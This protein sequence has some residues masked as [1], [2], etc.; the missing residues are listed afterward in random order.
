MNDLFPLPLTPFEQYLWTDDRP[1]YPMCSLLEM[2]FDGE[3]SRDAFE[4][5]L[6]ETVLRHPFLTCVVDPSARPRPAWTPRP[7]LR[8]SVDWGR[9]GDPLA[10]PNGVPIDVT[11]ES[12]M[13]FWI[14]CGDGRTEFTLQVHHV[15]ADGIGMLR[16]VGDLLGAYSRLVGGNSAGPK[17]PSNDPAKLLRR[18]DV[19]FQPPEP[20]SRAQI[21]RATIRETARWFLL[22]PTQLAAPHVASKPINAVPAS[23]PRL[24]ALFVDRVETKQLLSVA[25]RHA[26]TLNDLLLRDMF[27]A[28]H[29]WNRRVNPSRPGRWLRINMPVDL[30]S[31]I[32]EAS[33]AANVLSYTF[34]TR[35]ID[36]CRDRAR[37]LEGIVSETRMI[38]RWNLGLHFLGGLTTGRKIPGLVRLCTSSPLCF[39]TAVQ[40][41]MGELSRRF[42]VRFPNRDGCLVMGNLVLRR[43]AATPPIRPKT[44]V[45]FAVAVYNGE[46][47]VSGQ[48]DSR[49]FDDNDGEQF[50][51]VLAERLRQ[52]AAEAATDA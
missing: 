43:V 37:L 38:K 40:S 12:G 8:P 13:R 48:Y 19:D 7:G 15:T 30:R 24:H 14:R 28:I 51:A 52:S 39:A 10:L 3:M 23:L 32:H 5:A 21:W 11:A 6:D 25:R 27:L 41:F 42:G 16:M 17:L 9:L 31:R 49:F 4:Q 47:T 46:L 26:V 18:G 34:I 35:R 2:F 33:P 29:D 1:A 50:L 22:R 45:A 44:R 20:I 36:D